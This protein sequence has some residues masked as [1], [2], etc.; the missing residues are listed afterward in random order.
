V[1]ER[2]EREKRG[3]EKRAIERLKEEF[4]M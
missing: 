3:I 4:L 2:L 1:V